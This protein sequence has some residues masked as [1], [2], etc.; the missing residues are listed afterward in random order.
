M[1]FNSIIHTCPHVYNTLSISILL[2]ENTMSYFLSTADAQKEKV[3]TS[4]LTSYYFDLKSCIIY[5]YFK[6]TSGFYMCGYDLI[7]YQFQYIVLHT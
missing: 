6:V 5:F 1:F 2:T 3:K 4:N 7:L